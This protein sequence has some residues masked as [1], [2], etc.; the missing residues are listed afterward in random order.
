M[1]QL[2][3]NAGTGAGWLVVEGDESDRSVLA[4][5]PQI[6]VVTNVELDHHAAW[7]SVRGAP[8]GPRG[9]AGPVP[10][11]VRGWELEPVP[12][13]LAVPGEHNRLNAAAALAAL[14]LSG[15]GA[16]EGKEVALRRFEGTDRR[17]PSFVGTRGG[18]VMG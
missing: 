15:V 5:R 7:G 2:G 17:L 14:E 10:D 13:P 8:G 6:A 9:V 18:G 16:E 3:G 1:P 11:V 4:L 12:F